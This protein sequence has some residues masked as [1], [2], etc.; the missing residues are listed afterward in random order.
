MKTRGH[1]PGS[2]RRFTASTGS[3]LLGFDWPVYRSLCFSALLVAAFCA[4][5]VRLGAKTSGWKDTQGASFRGEPAEILGPWA[6]FRTGSV[7]GRRLLL[8]ALAP[9]DCRRFHDE[10][11]HRPAPAANWIDARGQA[12]GDLVGHVL[13][14]SGKTL[15]P[16][17]LAHQPEPQ[18]LLVLFGSHNDGESWVMV[19]S[20]MAVQQRIQR[21]FPGLM[22]TVFIGVRHNDAEHREMALQSGMPW[23]VAN[24]PEQAKLQVLSRFA[25]AE[26]TNMVLLSREGVPLLAA[27]ATDNEAMRQ[28]ADQ[29]SDIVGLIDP[30]NPRNWRDRASYLATVR[31]VE[32]AQSH[33]DPVLIGN[34]LRP[35][36]LGKFGVTRVAARLEV[37]ASGKVT[38]TLRSTAAEVPPA[39]V[40]PLTDALRQAVVLPAIDHGVAVAGGLD[41]TLEVPPENLPAEADHNWLSSASYPVISIDQWLVLRPIKVSEQDFTSSVT[42]ETPSGTVVFKAIQVSDAKVSRAAQMNAFNSDW[43]DAAG[44][45]SVQPKEGEKQNVDSTPLTWERVKADHGFVDL[46]SGVA[47]IDYTVGY[48]FAEFDAA[49]A[50]KAWLGIG[51]DDGLKIWLNGELVHDKWIR[52]PSRIDDDVVPLHLKAGRNRILLKIQ[53][54]TG[55]WSFIYRL[56]TEPK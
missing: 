36:A 17:D 19:G 20:M 43:F 29:L 28:F 22:G 47:N 55:D 7:G 35:E 11:S 33:A 30:A 1:V 24:F 56:R 15:V 2:L 54:A 26:G 53:N 4:T 46:R 42:D 41:F 6:L 14:V 44:P 13:Q 16:A 10:I 45:A 8:G 23:L 3:R 27:R 12:T 21:V 48:A 34:P 9:E 25:P 50:G 52:R 37:A 38:P 49:A 31:P 5:G 18:L 51:S 39:L 32:F 40:G